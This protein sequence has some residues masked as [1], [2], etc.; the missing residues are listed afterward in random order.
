V[1]VL[2]HTASKVVSPK[3]AN[4]W[5]DDWPKVSDLHQWDAK[6]GPPDL[7]EYQGDT[8][9]VEASFKDPIAGVIFT[10]RRHAAFDSLSFL[11]YFSL[12]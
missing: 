1:G 8:V 5:P 2:G 6:I 9:L 12:D 10:L 7:L 3:M 4:S 11:C